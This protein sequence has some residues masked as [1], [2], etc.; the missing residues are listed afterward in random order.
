[1]RKKDRVIT[2]GIR[3]RIILC[4]CHITPNSRAKLSRLEYRMKWE[5]DFPG[6]SPETAG[7]RN[8][9]SAC[10]DLNVDIRGD[11]FSRNPKTLNRKNAG[12]TD[13]ESSLLYQSLSRAAVLIHSDI[14]SG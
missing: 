5:K 11:R 8:R 1:M 4:D 3:R 13:E 6:L 10:A 14:L 2:P 7:R 9:C 12:F